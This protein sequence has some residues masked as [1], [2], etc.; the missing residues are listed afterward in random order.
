LSIANPKLPNAPK[1][2][3]FWVLTWYHK[4]KILL[5][6][7]C[8]RSQSKCR[9]TENIVWN[10]IHA[11]SLRCIW[12]I[13]EFCGFRL[14]SHPQIT[15]ISKYCK[16][17]TT[18]KSRTL[19][20]SNILGKVYLTCPIIPHYKWETEAQRTQW[21]KVT[22]YIRGG[23]AGVYALTSVVMSFRYICVPGTSNGSKEHSVKHK[24]QFP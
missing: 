5:L 7:S 24:L 19:R 18:L 21:L 8:D 20:L 15:C 14:G 13:N 16:I 17:Q 2:Q 12:N 1:S 9:C 3:T 6:T 10:Y 4:W 22:K 11:K 23:A